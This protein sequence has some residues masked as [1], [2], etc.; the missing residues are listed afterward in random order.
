MLLTVEAMYVGVRRILKISV[1]YA[2]ICCE[3][4]IALKK[5]L[6]QNLSCSRSCI[7]SQ[8][9]QRINIILTL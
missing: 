2:Q 9:Y 6:L 8:Q 7:K 4:T 1:S 5:S 3:P